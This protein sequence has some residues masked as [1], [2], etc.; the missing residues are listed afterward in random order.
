MALI[1]IRTAFLKS[2]QS[3]GWSKYWPLLRNSFV[4]EP[5]LYEREET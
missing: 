4:V 2:W 1:P 3:F 5:F